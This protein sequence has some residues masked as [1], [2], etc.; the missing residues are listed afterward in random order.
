MTDK[1]VLT[2]IARTCEKLGAWR[3]IFTPWGNFQPPTPAAVLPCWRLPPRVH[4]AGRREASPRPPLTST[5]SRS[6]GAATLFYAAD[7]SDNLHGSELP[8]SFFIVWHFRHFARW[9]Y[10]PHARDRPP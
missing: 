1:G 10:Q 6:P 2:D 5:A 9:E 8:R 3:A 4:D 7:L